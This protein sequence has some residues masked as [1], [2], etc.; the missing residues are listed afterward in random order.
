MPQ[1]SFNP[2]QDDH[3]T[4]WGG[5]GARLGGLTLLL[6]LVISGLAHAADRPNIVLVFAD[7][8]GLYELGCYGQEKILTPN[9]DRLA[10]EGMRFT[11]F[12]SASTVCAPSRCSLLTGMHTG[13]AFIRGNKEVGGWGPEDHEGQQPL[14]AEMVTLAERLKDLGYDTAAFGKWGL[15]GPGSTGHP[16]YQGFDHFYGYL[17]QR[18]AHNYYPTHL[19]RNHDV[20]VLGGNRYFS[21]H[22]RI[23]APLE[24]E[25]EYARRFAGGDYAPEQ[26]IKEAERWI[27]DRAKDGRDAPFFV[28]YASIIPHVALQAPQ[29]FVDR[30][31]R[32]WDA[33]PYLGRNGYLP[34][35]R[36]RATYAAMIS[37]L[38]E[39]VGRLRVALE[40]SGQLDNT[41]I[42]F[43]SD[44]GTTFAGGVDRVFFDSLGDLRGFKTNLYEGGIREPLIAW[45]P[46]HIGVGYESDLIAQS[47]DLLPTII[48]AAGGHAPVDIDG[49]SI[50]PTL[51]SS[52]EQRVH[53]VLYWEF[54]EGRQQQA[55]LI[56]GRWKAI[57]PDLKKGLT[58]ELYDI[59][60]DPT[61]S[62]DVAGDRPEIVAQAEQLMRESRFPSELFPIPALDRQGP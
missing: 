43:T 54:P 62:T 22:Q 19:W 29:D 10:A 6:M 55:V 41:I 34:N 13:H 35:P 5:F 20:D 24:D 18:V 16:C 28:Y 45:W 42:L 57:R 27:A 1:H 14:P 32:S 30:Y 37:F 26:I 36:P 39:A 50:L 51:V 56:G 47:I 17:C 59:M 38:D 53:D 52:G 9:I 25:A 33:E 44:N 11:R 60:H 15:G 49:F 12:Y 61:E 3:S 40:K 23:D 7:D 2:A 58:L 31:P 4:P 8:L 48:E 46:G 21:A